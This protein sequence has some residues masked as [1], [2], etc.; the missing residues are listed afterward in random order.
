MLVA[1]LICG[2]ERGGGWRRGLNLGEGVRGRGGRGRRRGGGRRGE[3]SR[4]EGMGDG[5]GRREVYP[6]RHNPPV[7]RRHRLAV[8]LVLRSW[9]GWCNGVSQVG[10]WDEVFVGW[11]CV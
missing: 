3:G 1:G 8:V 6:Y 9:L 2:E 10:L 5:G 4:E 7:H 11:E